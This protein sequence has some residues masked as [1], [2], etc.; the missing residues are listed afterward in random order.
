MANQ[1]FVDNFFNR[2]N[3]N[4]LTFSKPLYKRSIICSTGDSEDVSVLINKS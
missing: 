3:M 4:L 1:F 2:Y